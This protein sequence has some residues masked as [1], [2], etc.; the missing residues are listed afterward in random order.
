MPQHINVLLSSLV[1]RPGE[2]DFEVTV[3]EAWFLPQHVTNSQF[4]FLFSYS[5]KTF[6]VG[7][8]SA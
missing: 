5:N 2:G 7:F 6:I 4:S 1:G 8:L 3:M